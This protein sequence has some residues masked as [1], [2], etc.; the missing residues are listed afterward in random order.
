L[1]EPVSGRLRELELEKVRLLERLAEIG[2]QQKAV[3]REVRRVERSQRAALR[4]VEEHH[5]ADDQDLTLEDVEKWLRSAFAIL[6]HSNPANPHQYWNRKRCEYPRMYE[7]VVR[8]VL[9]HGYPQEYGG[10]TYVCLDV[11]LHGSRWFIW[12]M[13]REASESVVLNAKP[14]ALRPDPEPQPR[15]GDA[16]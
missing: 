15:L 6:A 14:S 11:E 8:Y 2:A 5:V 4:E 9:E 7:R 16:L 13:V 3:Q 1:G 12:P 10:E